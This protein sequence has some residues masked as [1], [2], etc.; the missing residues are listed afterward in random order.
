MG[1]V[2][3]K[4]TGWQSGDYACLWIAG[5]A[6]FRGMVPAEI[7]QAYAGVRGMVPV[8]IMQ[9]CVGMRDIAQ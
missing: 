5:L 4:C 3:L 9:T 8:E 2:C 1:L 6:G 7:V